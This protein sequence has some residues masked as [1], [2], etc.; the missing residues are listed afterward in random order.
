VLCWEIKCVKHIETIKVGN[1]KQ[2]KL[3]NKKMCSAHEKQR[4]LG[5][6]KYVKH[7]KKKLKLGNKKC[8]KHKMVE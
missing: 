7:I 1:N 8:V 2:R 5:N 4:K 6:K 3:G